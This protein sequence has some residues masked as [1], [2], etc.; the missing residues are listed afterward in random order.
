MSMD[1]Q[2]IAFTHCSAGI[3]RPSQSLAILTV[4]HQGPPSPSL[5]PFSTG[6]SGLV[7]KEVGECEATDSHA[8]SLNVDHLAASDMFAK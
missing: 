6:H 3:R 7:M 1:L 8:F 5:P 4:R 2:D